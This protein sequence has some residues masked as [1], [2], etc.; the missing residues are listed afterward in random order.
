MRKFI[1]AAI[2]GALPAFGAFADTDGL[3]D[4]Y[5]SAL[6]MQDVFEI[7]QD[8]GVTSAEEI[9]ETD[10]A[11][12]PSP[13]WS[14]RVARLYATDKMDAIFRKALRDAGNLDVSAPAL[15]F[16]ETELGARIIDIEIEARRALADDEVED[17]VRERAEALKASD[18]DRY[19]LYQQFIDVNDLIESNLMGALN[20]NLAFYRGL[21]S[22]PG[23]GELDEQSI[24]SRVYEGAEDIRE[25]MIDWTMNF[26][27]LA[28]SVLTE[29]EMQSYIDLSQSPAG[30]VLN[31]ALFAGFDNVFELHSFE[32]GRAMGEFMQ[33]DDT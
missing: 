24:L 31:S 23:F 25:N 30:E 5:M 14:S 20:S 27:V 19:A 7:L 33:G 26:S 6:K 21:G 13:A 22:S 10:T 32:L 2:L 15:A 28:Y 11:I 9:A 4:R 29:E 8:E 16:F 18:P 3:I 1:L 17:A 12:T